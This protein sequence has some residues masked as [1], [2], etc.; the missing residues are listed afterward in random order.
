MNVIDLSLNRVEGGFFLLNGLRNPQP[1]EWPL[2][3]GD[4]FHF[5]GTYQNSGAP[6]RDCLIKLI[7]E[8]T[9]RLFVAS[10]MLGDENVI[11]EL[12]QAAERLKGG[13]YVITALDDKSLR[14]G[15]SEYEESEQSK[16]EERQKNFR[17]LTMGGIYVRGHGECHAKFAV[18]DDQV[19]LVGSANFVTNA[20]E[21]TN[22]A[23]ILIRDQLQVR[24]AARLFTSLWYGGCKWEV[25][26][27]QAYTVSE[28]TTTEPPSRPDKP[29]EPSNR[30]VWTDGGDETHLLQT[31]QEVA[32]L[33]RE[34]LVLCS[35]SMVGMRE[36]PHL[37]FD[38]IKQAVDRG[39]AVRLLIRQRNAWP[40][41]MN[42][43]LVLD[44]MGVEIHADT[45]NHAKVAVADRSHGVIF[46]ANLD[47]NHGLDSGVEVGVRLDDPHALSHLNDY[48][49]HMFT[50]A[51]T[52]FVRNPTIGEL[53]GQLAA[54]WCKKWPLR[55]GNRIMAPQ[56]IAKIETFLHAAEKGL[57]LYE[58]TGDEDEV[59][60]YAED[61]SAVL[62]GANTAEEMRIIRVEEST[63]AIQRLQEWLCSVR[64]RQS[65]KPSRRGFCPASIVPQF[66]PH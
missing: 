50:N 3:N 60:L 10:F 26:P 51:N 41:Q 4:S 42:D 53:D 46:S 8:A 65:G 6:I 59:L 13:V 15:L 57:C 7:R 12:L 39:V 63:P 64:R 66:G 62:A 56:E 31:I 44:D 2:E 11:A 23:N 35:Y 49:E 5:V 29:T 54:R 18:A 14:K 34:Q 30:L 17:R 28:R 16:P 22:E 9:H 52:T 45:R 1:F 38:H 43:L 27:G 61:T 20:F 33:A 40:D 19:A 32:G 21:W 25:P 37:V 47:A 58:R 36:N 48:L 55:F 24:Q